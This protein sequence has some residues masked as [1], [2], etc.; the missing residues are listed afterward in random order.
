MSP[1]LRVGIIGFDGVNAIDLS[2]PLEAFASASELDREPGQPP[3]YETVVLGLSPRPFVTDSGLT[4]KAQKQLTAAPPLD[5]LIIPG[6]T[7]LRVPRT[8]EAVA[9][10]LRAHGQG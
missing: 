7:G 5:T 4:C 3:R 8:Q 6:G 9:A 1:T 10:W 2:G